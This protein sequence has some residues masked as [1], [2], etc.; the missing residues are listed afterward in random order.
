MPHMELH[1]VARGSTLTHPNL[2]PR[3]CHGNNRLAYS[4][5]LDLIGS[6]RGG[7][8]AALFQEGRSVR[9]VKTLLGISH[10]EASN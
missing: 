7:D 1:A 6:T 8:L 9:Q 5:A 10:G 3:C 4:P 2:L